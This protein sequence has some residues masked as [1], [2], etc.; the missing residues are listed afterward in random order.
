MRA[1]YSNAG[2]TP[3]GGTIGRSET[4]NFNLSLPTFECNDFT[5]R[6]HDG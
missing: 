2:L 1:L 6:V 4:E 5:G 3:S